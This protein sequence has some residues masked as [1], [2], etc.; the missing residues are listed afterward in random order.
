MKLPVKSQLFYSGTLAYHANKTDHHDTTEKLLK[1]TTE[2]LLKEM[3]EILLKEMTEILLKE[4][5]CKK[6]T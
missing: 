2:K 4:T 6:R 1:E 3:T 5:L